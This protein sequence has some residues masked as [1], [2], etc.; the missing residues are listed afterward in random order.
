MR[1]PKTEVERR[2]QVVLAFF[3][4]NPTAS[5]AKL[6][7]ALTSGALTGKAEKMLN[8]ATGY[9]WRKEAIATPELPLSERLDA[10]GVPES[11][12]IG[13]TPSVEV[14][15]SWESQGVGEVKPGETVTQAEDRIAAES[16]AQATAVPTLLVVDA[17]RSLPTTLAEHAAS[18]EKV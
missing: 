4:K 17:D 3:R 9:K 13:G 18:I 10:Q 15:R 8:I 14:T 2:R 5:V 16:F 1:L 6:N 12:L 7:A 11:P